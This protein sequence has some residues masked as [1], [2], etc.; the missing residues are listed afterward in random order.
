[1]IIKKIY[2]EVKLSKGGKPYA[3]VTVCFDE[4]KDGDK[5]KYI[6]GFGNKRTWAWKVGDDV[7]PEITEKDGKYLNFSFDD[8]KENYLDVKR[9]ACTVG[10]VMELVHGKPER[11]PEQAP[12]NMSAEDEA[13]AESIPF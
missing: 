12:V 8:S 1:M 5:H 9:L 2:K 11:K 10:F 4:Y 13:A 7:N 6:S 3:S